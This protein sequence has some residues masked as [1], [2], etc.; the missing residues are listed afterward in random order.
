[1]FLRSFAPEAIDFGLDVLLLVKGEVFSWIS[2]LADAS[3]P[4]WH[5]LKSSSFAWAFYFMNISISRTEADRAIR[6]KVVVVPASVIYLTLT[7]FPQWFLPVI[8]CL[9]IWL[10]LAIQ[11]DLRRM[12][13]RY[14]AEARLRVLRAQGR[15]RDPSTFAELKLPAVV[16][17]HDYHNTE[18]I[19]CMD[20]F[21]DPVPDGSVPQPTYTSP[22]G[23]CFHQSCLVTWFNTS[24]NY[25]CPTCR[26]SCN[27]T[28]AEYMYETIF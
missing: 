22:C 3:V 8:G 24:K 7:R 21:D 6:L 26:Q 4:S 28:T 20:S 19:I 2:G 14:E 13:E 11:M 10:V 25:K 9:L 18:C 17:E 5:L 23:H 27:P 1:M 15:I 16:P 12:Q